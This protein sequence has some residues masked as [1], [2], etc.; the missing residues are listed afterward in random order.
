MFRV[1][2]CG[3]AVRILRV[4][5]RSVMLSRLFELSLGSAPLPIPRVDSEILWSNGGCATLE[6]VVTLGLWVLVGP[7]EAGNPTG[8]QISR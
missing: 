2:V 6:T 5:I 4:S 8:L 7:L 3:G 1:L